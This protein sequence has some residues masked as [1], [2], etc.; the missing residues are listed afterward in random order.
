LTIS[1]SI[2]V[3]TLEETPIGDIEG[4]NSLETTEMGWIEHFSLS[5]PWSHLIAFHSSLSLLANLLSW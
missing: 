4:G 5:G 2:T 3:G 1:P